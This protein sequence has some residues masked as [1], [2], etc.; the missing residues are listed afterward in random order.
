M[1]GAYHRACIVSELHMFEHIFVARP[2]AQG[3]RDKP[4]S[5]WFEVQDWQTEMWFSAGYKAEVDTLNQ[6][7]KLISAGYLKDPFK[8]INL[9]EVKP[10]VLRR[11]FFTSSWN[12][13][14]F[15]TKDSTKVT[16]KVTT[17]VYGKKSFAWPETVLKR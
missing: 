5:N 3:W 2:L 12:A 6:I 10:D 16:I 7:N 1:D 17:K 13:T 15:T 11:D 14:K 9:I 4:P 8:P